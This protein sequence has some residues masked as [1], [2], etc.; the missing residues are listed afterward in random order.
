MPSGSSEA[1]EIDGRHCK[2][3]VENEGLLVQL[4]G[5]PGVEA[6]HEKFRRLRHIL[7]RISLERRVAIQIPFV[8]CEAQVSG[9]RFMDD[10]YRCV[11]RGWPD[12]ARG[13]VKMIGS[14]GAWIYPEH[15]CVAI[16]GAIRLNMPLLSGDLSAVVQ[17]MKDELNSSRRMESL[18]DNT[19]AA[20]TAYAHATRSTQH[21]WRFLLLVTHLEALASPAGASEKVRDAARQ[22]KQSIRAGRGFTDDPDIQNTL[23]VALDVAGKESIT[24][25]V[26]RLIREHCAPGVAPRPLPSLFTD[27]ADCD[28]KVRAMYTLRSQYTHTGGVPSP[29][30]LK[31]YDFSTLAN[32]AGASLGHILRIRLGVPVN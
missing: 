32:V 2:L 5:L 29:E 18:D 22:L 1:I 11:Q 21:V 31:G 24:A 19:F 16:D 15:E 8:A 9:I 7:A 13:P 25:A 3:S 4:Q 17:G 30:R 10:D 27:A 6:A 14:D 20:I 26:Q 23:C 28:A 12:G